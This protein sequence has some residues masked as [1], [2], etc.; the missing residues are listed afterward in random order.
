MH[1]APNH[2]ESREG[3]A[4]A[5]PSARR[6]LSGY[7]ALAGADG[8]ALGSG[9]QSNSQLHD[10]LLEYRRPST[11]LA[12]GRDCVIN[13]DGSGLRNLT[14]HR[15][16]DDLPAWQPDGLV[17]ANETSHQC[18]AMSRS[19]AA[20]FPVGGNSAGDP[21]RRAD[22]FHHA[23]PGRVVSAPGAGSDATGERKDRGR[24]GVAPGWGQSSG[25]V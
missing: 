13:A 10:G 5:K 7:F 18:C 9:R 12:S 4:P 25:D 20:R 2:G 6:R 24:S 21:P 19:G 22:R 1:Y 11:M 3:E 8:T 23:Q 14:N 17:Y 16:R 15:T